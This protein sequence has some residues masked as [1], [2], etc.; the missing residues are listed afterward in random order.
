M[1]QISKFCDHVEGTLSV[2]SSKKI[3]SM[4]NSFGTGH[5]LVSANGF[6]ADIIRFAAGEGVQNH[7]HPG[8]HIL[9]VLHGTGYVIYA[10]E[11]VD[12]EPGLC[13]FVNGEVD[14]AI[15]AATD[16]VMIAVGNQHCDVDS[17]KRM[18]P[19]PYR[20]TTDNKYRV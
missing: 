8:D 15:K 3:K 20:D 13:Y 4:V 18:S 9:F 19:V 7:T 16:L 11:I 14:H 10:G 17:E 6:G 12:L 2:N 5:A 1:V